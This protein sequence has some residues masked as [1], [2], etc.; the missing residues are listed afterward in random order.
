MDKKRVLFVANKKDLYGSLDKPSHSFK[1]ESIL[2]VSAKCQMGI[3]E[4][5]SQILA[6]LNGLNRKDY[7]DMVFQARHVA[8]L[9]NISRELEQSRSML[10]SKKS[11]D[12]ICQHLSSALSEVHLLLGKSYNDEILDSIFKEFCIG[13]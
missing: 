1:D 10:D 8:H 12:L 9:T 2:Q 7:K 11:P 5:K 3:D 13:K 6:V 4:L